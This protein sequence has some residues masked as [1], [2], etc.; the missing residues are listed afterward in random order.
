M[1]HSRYWAFLLSLTAS[2]AQAESNS[3][4][5]EQMSPGSVM[6]KQTG[7]NN[8][9]TVT[10]DAPSIT[11]APSA[12]SQDYQ[13][14]VI[15]DARYSE[16]GRVN[17]ATSSPS[18]NIRGAEEFQVKIEQDGKKNKAKVVQK[19]KKNKAVVKQ[20]GEEN[21]RFIEQLGESNKKIIIENGT[22]LPE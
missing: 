2:H 1:K 19:G 15:N 4:V 21:Q 20:S 11:A 8:S 18:T 7:K 17:A 22:I 9:V 13:S 14:A 5:V 10:Q 6:V 16:L 3:V 12:S